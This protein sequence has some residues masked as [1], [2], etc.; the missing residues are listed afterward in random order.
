MT[1]AQP[2]HVAV[3]GAGAVG[4]FYGAALARGGARVSVVCRSHYEV[5][6]R[7]GF[8]IR[9]PTMGD[10]RFVP[11]K[12]VARAQD[13]A[14]PVDCVLLAVKVL[15]QVD[16]A[17]LVRPL[18][19]PSSTLLLIQNGI[20]I[21]AELASAFP[22]NE[23]LSALAFIGVARS[24]PGEIDHQS[25]GNLTLGRYP[26]GSSPAAQ[27][28]AARFASG[29]VA[30][31][32]TDDVITARWQKAV[33]NA[34]FNPI[35]VAGGVLDTATML[36]SEEGEALVRRAALEVCAVAAAAGH[37]QAA[38]LVE[39]YIAGTRAMPAYKTSMA[40]DLE[41]GRPLEIEAILGNAVRA[42]RARGVAI[43]TLEALYGLCKMIEHKIAA[44]LS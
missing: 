10:S 4:A 23:L 17:A 19:G 20:D 34:A 11:A 21:E 24:A 43:P 3:V 32:L 35:S 37:P 12:V 1:E 28:L 33:W 30:C 27:A 14:E 6:A 25:F 18:L 15:P 44:R 7:D 40:L 29:G 41:H 5:V 9:S 22:R 39:R 42:G 31:A 26:H 13:L 36:A 38:E 16:R 8:H 2:F